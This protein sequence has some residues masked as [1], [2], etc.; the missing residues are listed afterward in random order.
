LQNSGSSFNK[1]ILFITEIGI[2]KE[3]FNYMVSNYGF[4]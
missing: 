1:T 4:H 2:L 3:E